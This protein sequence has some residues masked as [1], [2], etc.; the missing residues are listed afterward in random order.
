MPHTRTSTVRA[1]FFRISP[2]TDLNAVK[3]Q[4]LPDTLIAFYR[5]YVDFKRA[6]LKEWEN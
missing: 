6:E 2:R 5:D 4:S 1:R 3:V